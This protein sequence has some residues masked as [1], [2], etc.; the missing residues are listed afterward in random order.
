VVCVSPPDGAALHSGQVI[1]GLL[2]PSARPGLIRD[3]AASGVTAIS[4]DQL[5][6]TLSRAQPMDALTSQANIT[7]YKAV[8]VAANAYGGYFPMLMTAAGTV[9]PASVLVLG[10]G[11]AGLQAIGT[12]RRLGAVVT[13]YDVRPEARDDVISLGARFLD[14]GEPVEA[15][16]SGDYA[17][18]LTSA[19]REAQQRALDDRVAGFD[20]VITTAGVPAGG[21]R[22]WSP[23]R[24]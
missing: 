15:S 20:I 12:A 11:V 22:C 7:G 19:E 10:A 24:R 18:A 17:R 9:R 2:Q 8:L 3:W 14:L 1:V 4:L 16:G 13:G 5:P 23:R 21:R 6:R